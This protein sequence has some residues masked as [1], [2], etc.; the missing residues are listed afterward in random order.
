[1]TT[2]PDPPPGRQLRLLEVDSRSL[3]VLGSVFVAAAVLLDVARSA[4]G[5]LVQLVI[6]TVLALALDRVV[7]LLQRALRMPRGAAVA[8]VVGAAGAAALGLFAITARALVSQARGG[9]IDSSEVA[10]QVA[11]AP[12]IGETLRR[13]GV[14]QRAE[15]WLQNLPEQLGSGAYGV[16]GPLRLVGDMALTATLTTL[17][18]VLML[19][20]GPRLVAT[21]RRAVPEPRRELASRI[22]TGLYVA[23]GRYAAGS[24]FLALLAGTAALGIG[25]A[26]GVPVVLAAGVWAALWNF[27]PQLG[28]TVGGAALV[29]LAATRGVGTAALALGLWL[30]Y[31]QLENRIVQPIVIGKA[32]RLTALATM[33]A[34]LA[35]AAVAGLVGAVLAVPLIAAVVVVRT[36]L[37][38]H[39]KLP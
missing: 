11:D 39:R 30:L 33:V 37:Q 29:A 38:P 32:V 22:G 7:T 10:A 17:L 13:Q 6:A 8:L 15:E 5:T 25:L 28:G 18:V 12:L 26:L 31:S 2:A 36:E 3:V 34:A 1:M 35:G 16:T 21:A 14:P 4:Y 23:V 9:A 27:V 20:E 19:L 24:V